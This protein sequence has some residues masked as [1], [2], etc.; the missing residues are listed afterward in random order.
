MKRKISSLYIHIPFC[1]NICPYCDFLKVFKNKKFEDLYTSQ[2]IKDLTSLKSKFH[3]FKTIYIGGGTPS[4]L[5]HVN[6]EKI[7]M[8]CDKLHTKFNY[9]FT[10][11]SNPEDIDI[12]LLMLLK[13][14]G[15]NRIS[16]GVQTFNSKVLESINRNYHLDYINL[17]NLIKKYINNINLDF[18]YGLPG[19]SLRTLKDDLSKFFELDVP[20]ASFYSLIISPGT[21]FFNKNIKEV[22]DEESSKLYNLILNEMRK[23]GF[24]RYEV[25]NYA[26]PGFESKHNLTYWRNK[27]YVGIGVGSSGYIDDV[28]YTNTRNLTC[29]L[30]GENEEEK[31]I[32]TNSLLKEYYFI[33]NL[34]LEK[35]FQL[36]EYKRIFKKDFLL[37]YK[38]TLSV[39]FKLGDVEV[40]NGYFKCTDKG[41]LVLDFLLRELIK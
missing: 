28:R 9:E 22:D 18:I 39:M 13:K 37:E 12:D 6:F 33:T 26:K 36:K 21:M 23:H 25:S 16:I 20:H 19:S 30:K 38:N 31:E 5:S 32:I 40:K 34:R 14:Y 10:I 3:L 8:V 35:G 4:C 24:D 29:Y 17:I 41:L 1:R 7:L 27:E 2:I 15:I 11:E